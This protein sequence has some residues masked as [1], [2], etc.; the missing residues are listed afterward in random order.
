MFFLYISPHVSF[1]L[2]S[3][4]YLC[5]LYRDNYASQ[6]VRSCSDRCFFLDMLIAFL[7]LYSVL[8][9][10]DHDPACFTFSESFSEYG[11]VVFVIWLHQTHRLI[12]EASSFVLN[13]SRHILH[14]ALKNLFTVWFAC[15]LFLF[16]LFWRLVFFVFVL[17]VPFIISLRLWVIQ[18]RYVLHLF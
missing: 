8:V 10:E 2:I 17:M 14:C 9:N 1:M 6:S 11:C 13:S 15:S 12:C 18:N 4:C 3:L 16:G 7:V 5:H